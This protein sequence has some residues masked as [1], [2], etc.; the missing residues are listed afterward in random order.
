MILLPTNLG[1]VILFEVRADV[2]VIRNDEIDLRRHV[3]TQA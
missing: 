2:N 1:R 3:Q